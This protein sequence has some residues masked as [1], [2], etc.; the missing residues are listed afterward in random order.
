MSRFLVQG[1]R[2]TLDKPIEYNKI[3]AII[4]HKASLRKLE[5]APQK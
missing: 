5:D 3:K 4:E 2:N 1:E